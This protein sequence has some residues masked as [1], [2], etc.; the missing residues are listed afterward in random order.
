MTNHIHLLLTPSAE[1]SIQRVI[2]HLGRQYVQYINKHYGRSGS[3]WE[4]RYKGSLVPEDHYLLSCYRYIELNP[5]TAGMV[6]K[7]EEYPWSSFHCN[8]VGK[9]DLLISPHDI[10]LGLSSTVEDR[11]FAYREL[12]NFPLSEY[13]IHEIRESLSSNHLLGNSRFKGQIEARLGHKIGDRLRGRPSNIS[14][15]G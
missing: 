9:P 4:G 13:D 7:P 10:Y 8:G 15:K 11:C 2:Q 12:F 3:L 6:E 1:N 14:N 5:V